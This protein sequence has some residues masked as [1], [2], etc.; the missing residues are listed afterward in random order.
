MTGSSYSACRTIGFQDRRGHGICGRR[1]SLSAFAE[2]L[3]V[4]GDEE[5]ECKGLR[6]FA[7]MTA[8]LHIANNSHLLVD[9]I[10]TKT[11][12]SRFEGKIFDRLEEEVDWRSYYSSH[13]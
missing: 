4:A 2:G 8:S 3:S 5:W 7:C 1:E 13:G 11:E 12:G 10:E 9:F 6:K